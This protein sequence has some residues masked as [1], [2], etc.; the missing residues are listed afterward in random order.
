M[1]SKQPDGSHVGK[2]KDIEPKGK[3]LADAYTGSNTSAPTPS[4][5]FETHIDEYA[6]PT[7]ARQ[8]A[9]SGNQGFGRSGSGPDVT[10]SMNRGQFAARTQHDR[11]NRKGPT[12]D[13]KGRLLPGEKD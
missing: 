3:S 2:I 4:R 5:G 10:S 8:I 11:G 7:E 12:G 13:S 1:A 9:G 6:N